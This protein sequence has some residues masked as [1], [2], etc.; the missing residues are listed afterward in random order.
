MGR[1]VTR[2]QCPD[3]LPLEGYVGKQTEDHGGQEGTVNR[4]IAARGPWRLREEWGGGT[5]GQGSPC[6]HPF[7]VPV[8]LPPG[9]ICGGKDRQGQRQ[10]GSRRRLCC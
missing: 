2:G 4:N 9:L 7:P 1:E 10:G 5:G 3:H 6:P 8:L